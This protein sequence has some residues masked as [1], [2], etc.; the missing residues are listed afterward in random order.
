MGLMFRAP[1]G[2]HMP[3]FTTILHDLPATNAQ[4]ARHLGL[5]TSTIARYEQADAAPRAVMLALFWETRWGRSAADCE[6]AN[7]GAVYYSKAMG[8]EREN[9]ALKRQLAKLE[10]LLA[11]SNR[12]AA[13]GP[14][15]RY[16][17]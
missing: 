1:F 6:A 7:W 9:A 17:Q 15:F 11:E 2:A 16:G 10:T 4:V 14:F 12:T 5:T 3:A 8:L 13:N